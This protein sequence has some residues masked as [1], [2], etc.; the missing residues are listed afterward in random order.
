MIVDLHAHLGG[1]TPWSSVFEIGKRNGHKIGSYKEFI[2]KYKSI[3]K[4]ADDYFDKYSIIEKLQDGPAAVQQSVFYALIYAHAKNG[5]DIIELRF[6]PM[7]RNGNGVN[8]LDSI[9]L[10]A[11]RGSQ[12]ACDFY[13]MKAGIV[14]CMDRKLPAKSNKIIAEKAMKYEERG[15]IGIDIAGREINS[16]TDNNDLPKI[17]RSVQDNSNLGITI[18]FGETPVAV[19]KFN[20]FFDKYRP[21]RVGHGIVALSNDSDLQSLK[22]WQSAQRLGRPRVIEYCPQ[23]NIAAGYFSD[24]FSFPND[25]ASAATVCN[26]FVDNNVDFTLGTDA[27]ILLKTSINNQFEKLV[28]HGSM[29][30]MKELMEKAKNASFLKGR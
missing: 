21:D 20:E 3:P 16:L 6:N 2:S 22:D 14:I 13:G 18:H 7:F 23:S 19:G 8:D 17:V 29:I 9:I 30:N 1:S 12:E 10:A 27:P 28:E 26:I 15:V 11:C 4:D 5:H 25:W 24:V